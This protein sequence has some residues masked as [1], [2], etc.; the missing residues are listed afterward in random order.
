MMSDT[1]DAISNYDLGK[2]ATK[3][4]KTIEKA[5][6]EA[7]KQ[8]EGIV[9]EVVKGVDK[10]KYDLDEKM[11]ATGLSATNK[12]GSGINAGKGTV[13]AN[14]KS[15]ADAAAE[16]FASRVGDTY[17]WGENMV[18]NFAN[19]IKAA[20]EKAFSIARTVAN[21]VASMFR[22]SVPKTGPFAHDDLWGYHM[23]QNFANGMERGIPDVRSVAEEVALA[24][25][26]PARTYMDIDAV[27]GRS[28]ILTTDDIYTAFSM[29]IA[30]QDTR[31]VI[32]NR[33]FGRI[34]RE[35]G[36]A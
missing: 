2:S 25:A 8:G 32:G 35:Q 21:A 31:I 14:A 28:E 7:G 36:V 3:A 5:K 22:H 26:L 20:Q 6:P 11:Y 33:E 10:Q 24:A 1:S 29:A 4:V 15:V 9:K 19:G 18:T 12:M 30:E 16:K 34:L 17:G 23:I 13:N 27:S